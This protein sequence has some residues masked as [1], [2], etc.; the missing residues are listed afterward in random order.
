M[1]YNFLKKANKFIK[2]PN[3]TCDLLLIRHI[4]R[5]GVKGMKRGDTIECCD[6]FE[7]KVIDLCDGILDVSFLPYANN[8]LNMVFE[9]SYNVSAIERMRII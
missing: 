9:K 6:F 4:K 7:V 1:K 8:P 3:E 5:Y 2:Q